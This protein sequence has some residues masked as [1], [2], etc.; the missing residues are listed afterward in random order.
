[1]KFPVFNGMKWKR[2]KLRREI[3]TTNLK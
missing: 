2:E 1:V 3:I